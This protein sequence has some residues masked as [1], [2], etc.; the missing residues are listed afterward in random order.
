VLEATKEL[1]DGLLLPALTLTRADAV[2]VPTPFVAVNVYM[3]VAEG[4]TTTDPD[5]AWLPTPLF[6]FTAVAPATFHESVE[7]PP[8]MMP[9]GEERKEEITGGALVVV[10]AAADE[11]AETSPRVSYAETE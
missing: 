6:I 4:E 8:G 3:V 2:L 7:V 5:A 9:A 11:V 1:G 10:V